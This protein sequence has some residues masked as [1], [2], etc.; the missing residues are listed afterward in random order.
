MQFHCNKIKWTTLELSP[1]RFNRKNKILSVPKVFIRK[2]LKIMF[3]LLLKMFRSFLKQFL[4]IFC[5]VCTLV[6]GILFLCAKLSQC[7]VD[8]RWTAQRQV[9]VGWIDLRWTIAALNYQCWSIA[10]PKW[11]ALNCRN[12]ELSMLNYFNDEIICV[13]QLQRWIIGPEI[14]KRQ[15]IFGLKSPLPFLASINSNNFYPE[16]KFKMNFLFYFLYF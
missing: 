6:N 1:T 7:W 11:V 8:L 16:G 3:I 4:C 5:K 12:T 10:V 14:S 15:I 2:F 9:I 13:E